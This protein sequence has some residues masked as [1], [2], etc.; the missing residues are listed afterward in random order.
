MAGWTLTGTDWEYFDWQ[1]PIIW[2]EFKNAIQE[3]LIG[4]FHPYF[5][6]YF[7]LLNAATNGK[8]VQKKELVN[9]IRNG[10]RT[11]LGFYIF[12]YDSSYNKLS[13]VTDLSGISSVDMASSYYTAAASQPWVV[14]THQNLNVVKSGGVVPPYFS[15]GWR[16]AIKFPND[17]TDWNDS[18]FLYTDWDWD[19]KTGDIIGPWILSDI[20]ELINCMIWRCS[21]DTQS[22]QYTY[23]RNFGV[24]TGTSFAAAAADADVNW[25]TTSRQPGGINYYRK[26]VFTDS[27]YRCQK[28]AYLLIDDYISVHPSKNGTVYYIGHPTADGVF[29]QQSETLSENIFFEVPNS[30]SYTTEDIEVISSSCARVAS[31]SSPVFATTPPP[32]YDN[33]GGTLGY[34]VSFI[35]IVNY[36]VP[37]GFTYY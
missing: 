19:A 16:N 21:D 1:D 4:Y 11:Y 37:G 15:K 27:A 10:L 26:F 6:T 30:F 34:I 29:D 7:P 22:A 14:A 2:A 5:S 25:A 20:Q 31:E 35:P 13:Q 18:V 9:E 33:S 17:W 36:A 8:Y 3:R 24:G 28:A 32:N 23:I 12:P